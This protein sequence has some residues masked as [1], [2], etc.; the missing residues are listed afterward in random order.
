MIISTLLLSP[1]P[2]QPTKTPTATK[3]F[4][5]NAVPG[6]GFRWRIWRISS[7]HPTISHIWVLQLYATCRDVAFTFLNEIFCGANLLA[8][9]RTPRKCKCEKAKGLENSGWRHSQEECHHFDLW[10][11]CP[12]VGIGIHH[13]FWPTNDNKPFSNFLPLI[14]DF[15]IFTGWCKDYSL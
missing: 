15:R 14:L 13:G 6:E 11:I 10:S 8:P 4:S 5:A 9:C 1:K 12:A 2:Y 3:E 7:F